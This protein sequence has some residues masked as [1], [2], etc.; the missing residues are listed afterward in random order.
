M[1]WLTQFFE[2]IRNYPLESILTTFGSVATF[3]TGFKG[4]PAL[5]DLIFNKTKK[6]MKSINSSF[7]NSIEKVKLQVADITSTLNAQ[8]L[9]LRQDIETLGHIVMNIPKDA[10]SAELQAYINVIKSQS[11]DLA[12]KYEKELE[13][14]KNKSIDLIDTSK[15]IVNELIGIVEEPLIEADKKPIIKVKKK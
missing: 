2:T 12:I 15:E 13:K 6:N 9:D 5:F 3:V 1:T 14:I 4:I 10:V 11:S 8:I 7:E